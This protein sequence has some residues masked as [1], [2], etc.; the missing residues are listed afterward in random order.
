[1]KKVLC[2]IKI[3]HSGKQNFLPLLPKVFSVGVRWR[4]RISPCTVWEHMVVIREEPLLI[5]NTKA[6]FVDLL[7]IS[8]IAKGI[9]IPPTS[10]QHNSACTRFCT[11][12]SGMLVFFFSFFRR[13]S[14]CF[15]EGQWLR[16]TNTVLF[17]FLSNACVM[18]QTL[19]QAYYFSSIVTIIKLL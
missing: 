15:C 8:R 19:S 17:L 11:F 4:C 12:K 6:P 3:M 7:H 5:C 10:T 14:G 18:Y 9:R 2:K 16:H 1:M 13:I